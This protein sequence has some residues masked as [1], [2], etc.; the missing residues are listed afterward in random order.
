MKRDSTDP[1]LKRRLWAPYKSISSH[2]NPE[3]FPRDQLKLIEDSLVADLVGN[4]P[5]LPVPYSR[6]SKPT[7]H[8][9]YAIMYLYSSIARF[10]TFRTM[11]KHY[12]WRGKLSKS[13]HLQFTYYLFVHECYILEER[14]K[15][16]FRAAREFCKEQNIIIDLAPISNVI[17]RLHKSAFGSAVQS[18]GVH[19]HKDDFLPHDIRRLVLF[20]LLLLGDQEVLELENVLK[21]LQR[22]ALRDTK[23]NWMA[24]CDN[25]EAASQEI[26]A[27]AFD[28]TEPVWSRLA[29]ANSWKK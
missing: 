15:A 12:P 28:K 9:N 29:Q 23:K 19:V 25:A 2:L 1:E 20:D 16:Y 27:L 14:L 22:L 4:R 3:N 18:R 10:A 8:L 7:T 21:A 11:F 6:I 26:V 5:K 13:D 24:Q 17:L